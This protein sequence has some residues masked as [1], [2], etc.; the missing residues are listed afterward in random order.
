MF[1]GVGVIGAPV[2]GR[3][4]PHIRICAGSCSTWS[5][6]APVGLE[7][8]LTLDVLSLTLGKLINEVAFELFWEKPSHLPCYN[9]YTRARSK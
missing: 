8:K 2:S 9:M 5:P 6:V 3:G 7:M 1:S 4:D